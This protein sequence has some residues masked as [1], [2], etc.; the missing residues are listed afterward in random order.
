MPV[1]TGI[2]DLVAA[3]QDDA[4]D[5]RGT[6]IQADSKGFGHDRDPF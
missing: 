3:V 6:D 1:V 5:G 2:N 4:F